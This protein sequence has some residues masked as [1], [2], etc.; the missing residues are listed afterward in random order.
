MEIFGISI[1]RDNLFIFC[2]SIVV[3]YLVKVNYL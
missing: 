1:S 3:G 2:V